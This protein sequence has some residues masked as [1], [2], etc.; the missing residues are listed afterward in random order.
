MPAIAPVHRIVR[1][2]WAASCLFALSSRGADEFLAGADLSHLAFFESR[3]VA[4]R[5]KGETND[6]CV[7]LREK[8]VNCVRLRLFTS[9]PE[10]AAANPYN[11][12][13]NLDYTLPLAVRAK[14]A[15]H[16]LLLD[17]HYS[18]TWADPGK[19]AKPAAWTNLNFT[20][21]ET[22]VYEYSSNTLFAFKAAGAA[23]EYV[24]VGNEI[25]GGLLWPDGRVGGSYETTAQWSQF[26][27]LLKSA[28]RGVKDGAGDPAPK[29]MVHID[30]GGDWSAT[31]W[32]FDRLRQQEVEFDLIG[33]SYYPFWH[34]TLAALRTCLSNA[35]L[36]Y[37][38]PIVIVETAFPWTNSAAIQ[39]IP[40]TPEGQAQ[41]VAEFAKIMKSLPENRGFGAFWWG[42]EYQRIPGTGLAGFDSR[43]LFDRE[44]GV[45]P[46]AG[47]LGQLAQPVRL[48]ARAENGRIFLSWPLSGLGYSLATTTEIDSPAWA[49]TTNPVHISGAGITLSMEPSP[50]AQFFRLVRT[51]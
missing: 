8:G 49:S 51:N 16:K 11:Y 39:G 12:I 29:I 18:D 27:A 1:L 28:I 38:K 45:L 10:Q 23:P 34:G 47:A 17:F 25:I 22:R 14:R 35:V 6:A 13:N 5:D 46:A 3:G 15:G 42:A 26:G 31:Q 37:D 32:F 50:D 7:I 33:Q 30:R 20:Q 36:R 4:Y 21:L 41:F 2:L 19:Q 43:S 48:G 44:G 9:T 40:A 24:Q